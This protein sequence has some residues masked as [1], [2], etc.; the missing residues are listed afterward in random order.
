ME[1]ST[2]MREDRKV[3][4]I[5]DCPGCG[6]KDIPLS[7]KGPFKKKG[8][9]DIYVSFCPNCDR[10]PIDESEIKRYVSIKEL[11]EMGYTQD[12]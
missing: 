8:Y 6:E 2:E 5:I 10:V 1:G 9:P 7:T 11:K 3:I 4:P 12:V